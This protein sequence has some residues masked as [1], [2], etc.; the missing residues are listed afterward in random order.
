M[1]SHDELCEK[2]IVDVGPGNIE[3]P[4]GCK[5]RWSEA[6]IARLKAENERLLDRLRVSWSF[7]RNS[8]SYPRRRRKREAMTRKRP[9]LA[10]RVARKFGYYKIRW[11]F[12]CGRAWIEI[13]DKTIAQTLGD[14]L[15]LPDEQIRK[16]QLLLESLTS[17]AACAGP[18]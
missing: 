5:E 9:D 6:E 10:E 8:S 12:S 16:I 13:G 11:G 7:E 2:I 1:D 17:P 18:E 15:C 14:D 3:S 4:C